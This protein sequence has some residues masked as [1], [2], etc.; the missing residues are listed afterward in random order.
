VRAGNLR[1]SPVIKESRVLFEGVSEITGAGMFLI[2]GMAVFFFTPVRWGICLRFRLYGSRTLNGCVSDAGIKPAP[3]C[4][5]KVF[6]PHLTSPRG[7]E[8]GQ[9]VS[10]INPFPKEER[11]FWRSA[12]ISF[13]SDS[14]N[15]PG[16]HFLRRQGLLSPDVFKDSENFICLLFKIGFDR[17]IA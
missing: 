13:K 12:F 2:V 5:L 10:A 6:S 16:I 4:F 15:D 9:W 11:K 17:F 7:G 3:T 1:S 14:F 8:E